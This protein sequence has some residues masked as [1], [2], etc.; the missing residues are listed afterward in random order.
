[1]KIKFFIFLII[2]LIFFHDAAFTHAKSTIKDNLNDPRIGIIILGTSAGNPV[3]QKDVEN[4]LNN[5]LVRLGFNHV[6]EV[7]HVIKLDDAQ[8]LESIYRGKT[9]HFDSE[10]DNSVDYLIVGKYVLKTSDIMI[11]DHYD[12]QGMIQSPLKNAKVTL[13]I[14]VIKYDT[15]EIIGSFSSEGAGIDNTKSRAADKAVEIASEQAAKKLGATLKKFGNKNILNLTFKITAGNEEELE[16]IIGILRSMESVQN[17]YTREKT[18][19]SAVISIDATQ[20]PTLIVDTLKK[21]SNLEINIDRLSANNCELR[22]SSSKRSNDK[23]SDDD[24]I[25][26]LEDEEQ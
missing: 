7:S 21:N 19:R 22:I 6:V 23:F 16:E 12:S 14:D 18:F 2:S 4:I 3:H 17:F 5:L 15:G 11:P 25:S 26:D 9:G 20:P 13:N 10:L 8:L 24:L 1:M